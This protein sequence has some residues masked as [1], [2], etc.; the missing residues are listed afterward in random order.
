MTSSKWVHV[1][2]SGFCDL[3]DVIHSI[4]ALIC[5]ETSERLYP[6]RQERSH[7]EEVGEKEA[8]GRLLYSRWGVMNTFAEVMERGAEIGRKRRKRSQK[9]KQREILTPA[10]WSPWHC[11]N[12]LWGHVPDKGEIRCSLAV[13]NDTTPN[14]PLDKRWPKIASG[15]TVGWFLR[16][17]FL[18]WKHGEEARHLPTYPLKQLPWGISAL[19]PADTVHLPNSISP[20]ASLSQ[21]SLHCY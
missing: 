18:F 11:S 16:L 14:F 4:F 13:S 10:F 9:Y 3:C 19:V 5:V 12:F 6:K 20:V 15:P 8:A 7:R 1:C 17:R 2:V 21:A